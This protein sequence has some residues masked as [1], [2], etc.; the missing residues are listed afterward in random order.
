MFKLIRDC[1][2]FKVET[3]DIA[4]FIANLIKTIAKITVLHGLNDS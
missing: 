2:I 1:K 4:A 3:H